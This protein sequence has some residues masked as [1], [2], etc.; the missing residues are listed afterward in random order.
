VTSSSDSMSST[1]DRLS[2]GWTATGFVSSSTSLLTGAG[3]RASDIFEGVIFFSLGEA[4]LSYRGSGEPMRGDTF[5]CAL[6]CSA[7]GDLNVDSV[8]DE[9]CEG[10]IVESMLG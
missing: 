3:L 6:L 9:S 2:A 7:I 5:S 4:A 1:S 8:D 10:D